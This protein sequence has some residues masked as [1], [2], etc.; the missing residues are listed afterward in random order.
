[1]QADYFIPQAFFGRKLKEFI[2][3]S[4]RMVGSRARWSLNG[5]VNGIKQNS[6]ECFREPVLTNK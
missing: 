3:V 6:R 5:F 2:T 4:G 1:M